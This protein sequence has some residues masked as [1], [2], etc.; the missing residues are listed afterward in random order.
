MM[1]LSVFLPSEFD[2][3]S[4]CVCVCVRH[5]LHRDPC[6]SP[7]AAGPAGWRSNVLVQEEDERVSDTATCVNNSRH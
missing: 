5:G 2:L 4:F 7:A 6:A 3:V 1:K